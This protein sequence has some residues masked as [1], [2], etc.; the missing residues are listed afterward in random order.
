M[1][2]SSRV[3]LRI[4]LQVVG[5]IT[6]IN[7]ICQT[8]AIGGII[9]FSED[10][11]PPAAQIMNI[12]MPLVIVAAGIFLLV[13]TKKLAEHLYPDDEETLDSA[14]AIFNLAMKIL[15][16]VLIVQALPDTVQIISNIIYLKSVSPAIFTD[17][18]Q[19]FIYTRLLST[20]LYLI[21]GFYLVKGGRLLERIA[22]SVT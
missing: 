19:E 9:P 2:L 16:M 13:G 12:L 5:V 17:L 7:G 8:I 15:G 20:L 18:Q 1:E 4:G 3:L 14:R 11:M 22:I 6:I 10:M 21:F